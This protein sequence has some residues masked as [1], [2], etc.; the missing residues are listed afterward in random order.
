MLPG[1]APTDRNRSLVRRGAIAA[2]TLAC[3]ALA[4]T[5]NPAGAEGS[6]LIPAVGGAAHSAPVPPGRIGVE[7]RAAVEEDLAWLVNQRRQ[8]AGLRPLLLAPQVIPAARE[9]AQHQ[10]AADGISHRADLSP[11]PGSVPGLPWV[12]TGENVGHSG[13]AQVL[14]PAVLTALDQAFYDSPKHRDNVLGPYSH[15]AVGA[16]DDGV[17]LYV[18]VAFVDW[19]GASVRG[20]RLPESTLHDTRS[21]LDRVEAVEGGVQ[22]TGWV[23]DPDGDPSM[24]ASIRGDATKLQPNVIRSDLLS[25]LGSRPDLKN[26]VLRSI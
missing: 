4:V 16:V 15:V 18:T 12:L 8:Q 17:D 2:V 14:G 23:S 5:I 20:E 9:W 13:S 6:T 10:A 3:V 25:V 7:D 11:Y 26:G 22:I 19:G 1:I 24:N 21:A